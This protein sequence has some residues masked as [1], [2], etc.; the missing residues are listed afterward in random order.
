MLGSRWCKFESVKC[1]PHKYWQ[2][3]KY[4]GYA[5]E[6][7]PRNIFAQKASCRHN[8]C[9]LH[10]NIYNIIDGGIKIWYES[11]K[12]QVIALQK[13]EAMLTTS[14]MRNRQWKKAD[15]RKLCTAISR[16]KAGHVWKIVPI[17][18][19]NNKC[20]DTANCNSKTRQVI[21]IRGVITRMYEAVSL[22]V[23]TLEKTHVAHGASIRFH[24][25]MHR[26]KYKS[27][28]LKSINSS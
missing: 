10:W 4:C 6:Y 7:W 1:V 28:A 17:T 13:A 15:C 18:K 26:A 14:S 27:Y 5:D 9:L 22:K 2:T 8:H 20:F 11:Q 25:W 21:R 3:Q 19:I 23:V 24:A 16:I 12:W